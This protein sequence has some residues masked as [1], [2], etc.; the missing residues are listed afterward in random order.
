MLPSLADFKTKRAHTDIIRTIAMKSIRLIVTLQVV[1]TL[2]AQQ[3][4]RLEFDVASVKPGD[5]SVHGQMVRS[6]TGRYE[7]HNLT[8][9]SLVLGAYQLNPNQLIGGPNWLTSSGW[10]ITATFPPA[11]TDDQKREMMRNLLA[12][13]FALTGHRETRE[14]PIYTLSVARGGPKMKEAPDAQGTMSAG[15]R[16]IRYSSATMSELAGQLSSYLEKQVVDKTSLPGRYAIDLKFIPVQAGASD[17]TEGGPTIF[18]ALQERLGLK[19]DSTRGPV[20][21]LV[22]DKAEKPSGN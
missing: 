21:V 16:M 2:Q 12:D 18:T 20:E 3:P 15:P 6:A 10:D 1:F 22:I 19:V 9:L 5:P 17:N 8:L 14:L 13:R 7:A 11:S 4:A